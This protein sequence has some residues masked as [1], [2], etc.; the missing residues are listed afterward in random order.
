[1]RDPAPG[2]SRRSAQ[3]ASS[4]SS[5]FQRVLIGTSSSRSSSSGACS[6]S[7]SVTGMPSLGQLVDRR[8]QADRR[9]GDAAG[10]TCPSPSGAGS[11]SRRTAPIDGLVVGQ[12]LAH[13]HE[14]DVGDPRRAPPGRR[15]LAAASAAR[16]GDDLLDD[17]G[18]GHVAGQAGLA[19]GAERAGHAAA[20]LAGDA[21]RDPVGVAHQH[22]TRRARRRT[23]ATASCGS[24][25]RRPR[26]VR[27]GVSS[28]GSSAATSSSADRRGQVGHLR[29]V[30]DEPLEVVRRAAARPGTRLAQRLDGR[31]RARRGS[32]SARCRG[33]LPRRGA[34]K[35]SCPGAGATVVGAATLT[36]AAHGRGRRQAS[37]PSVSAVR[38]EGDEDDGAAAPTPPGATSRSES[39]RSI[40]P[41]CPGRMLPMSLMP[42]SRLII[43][44]HRSPRVAG[45]GDG[46]ARAATPTHQAPSSSEVDRQ[47]RRRATQDT[48][49]PAKP[50]QDFFGLTGA[51]SGACRR[52]R[53]RRS[54]RCRCST[55]TRMKTKIAPGRRPARPASAPRSRRGTAR[56]PRRRSPPAMSR[57]GV[58]R[59]RRRPATAAPRRRSAPTTP[60]G[61]AAPPTYAAAI[62]ATRADH[63]GHE[64]DVDPP[65]APARR[66]APRRRR[67]SPPSTTTRKP[68]LRDEQAGHDQ[69]A[70]SAQADR[71]ARPAGCGPAPARAAPAGCRVAV[72]GARRRRGRRGRSWTGERRTSDLEQLGFL[73]L[74]QLV[75][76]VDVLLGQ[77]V[78]L[79]LG[80]GAVV[81]AD[82][83][84]LDEL[85][86]L[87]LGLAADVADRDLGVLGLGARPA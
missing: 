54:R 2:A 70:P 55:V 63:A 21:H 40:R 79:L 32:R 45:D 29:R 6:D 38:T 1:M 46:D 23:A 30:V 77:R 71:R 18:G 36:G 42:R 48:T 60:S 73:V 59:A 81:L 85:V 24:C 66:A 50:S 33:G 17:L 47:R 39:S 61:P 11:V 56:R 69:D 58:Q 26:S 14:H 34:A 62:I 75:D 9:H 74:E 72:A 4:A 31:R 87:L 76:R 80:A 68:S 82:L 15:R 86:E 37:R 78:E 57:D 65:L 64:R 8:H 43:D 28:G 67:R 25:R 3:A 19:G 49:E 52:A 13:A 35:V 20:G 44:S 12:R 7:A 84:V 41:P 53:P 16:A 5:T 27:T 10:A 22:A 51:P 83:A